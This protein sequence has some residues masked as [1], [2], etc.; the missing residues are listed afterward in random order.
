MPITLSLKASPITAGTSADVTVQAV[1]DDAFQHLAIPGRNPLDLGRPKN[2][3]YVAT[4]NKVEFNRIFLPFVM[5]Q[6]LAK[7]T[8]SLYITP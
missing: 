6:F 3:K 7:D 8:K 4:I 2:R 1:L 5:D